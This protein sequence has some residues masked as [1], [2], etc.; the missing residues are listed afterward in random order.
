MVAVSEFL[1]RD[2]FRPY[3]IAEIGVNHFDIADERG[4]TPLAAAR[5]MIDEAADAGAD[6]VKFQSYSAERLA[7]ENADAYWDT[8]EESTTSQRELFEAYDSFGSD[9]FESLAEYTTIKHDVDFLSTPFDLHA[10]EYLSDLVPTYK[11]ASADLTN[12]P[13]LEA[14]A[15]QEKPVLL[16]TG[17]STLSEV[18]RAVEIL[19]DAGGPDLEVCL[20]HCVLDYPTDPRDANLAMIEHLDKAFPDCAV[21]YSDHVP[22]DDGMITLLNAVWHGATIVE[23]HFTLDKSLPGND[24]YHAMDPDGLAQFVVNAEQV[25]TTSGTRCK[26]PLAVEE[27]SRKHARRSL[28]ANGDI[29]AGESIDRDKIRVKRPGTGIAPSMLDI[30][31]GRTARTDINSDDILTW[32]MI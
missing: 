26:R 31:V 13:L 8:D 15:T 6:A 1:D 12:E 18:A 24:H 7:S 20:L 11:I 14:V 10:V 16:S 23:K 3:V 25:E 5:T 30:V 17:A 29:K 19:R 21:G 28:V 32:E 4:I 2:R 22:P 27:D 9:E